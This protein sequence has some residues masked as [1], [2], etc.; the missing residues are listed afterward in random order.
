[1]RKMIRLR[2]RKGFTLIEF[3][4]ALIVLGILMAVAIPKFVRVANEA[5]DKALSGA[6]GE[7]KGRVSQYFAL[8]VLQGASSADI[9]YSA[10]NIDMN[11]GS[12]FEADI[13]S[14]PKDDPITGVVKLLDGSERTMSWTMKRP[15]N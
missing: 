10:T 8:Q 11:L 7:L 12:D 4:A 9:D 3:I 6:A 13:T 1:M 14:G 2:R 15:G 5:R